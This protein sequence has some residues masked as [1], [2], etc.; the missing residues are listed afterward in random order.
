VPDV[1]WRNELVKKGLLGLRMYR[2]KGERENDRLRN[3]HSSHPKP[4]QPVFS[5]VRCDPEEKR[6]KI[7]FGFVD[8]V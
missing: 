2:L 7:C 8:V 3:Y 4:S 6:G 1:W 5:I